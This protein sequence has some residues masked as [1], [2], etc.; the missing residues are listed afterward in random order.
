AY[1][2]FRICSRGHACYFQIGHPHIHGGF[3]IYSFAFS[4]C[5]G[6]HASL[7]SELTG[8]SS[9]TKTH[10]WPLSL[11]SSPVLLV[12]GKW[13]L[14]TGSDLFPALGSGIPVSFQNTVHERPDSK[15]SSWSNNS[16]IVPFR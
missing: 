2:D 12:G 5:P 16:I 14:F 15:L 7:I 10:L 3:D 1:I 9:T 8:S 11:L 6:I 13:L 4:K